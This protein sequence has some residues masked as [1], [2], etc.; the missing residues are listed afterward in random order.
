MKT[1]RYWK[2]TKIQNKRTIF[3]YLLQSKNLI[4]DSYAIGGYIAL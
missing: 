3:M 1:L 4:G 2:Y